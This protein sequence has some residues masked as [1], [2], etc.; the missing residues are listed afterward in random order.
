[1]ENVGRNSDE[2]I[3]DRISGREASTIKKGVST[4]KEGALRDGLE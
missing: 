3:K 4:G 1:V 2:K